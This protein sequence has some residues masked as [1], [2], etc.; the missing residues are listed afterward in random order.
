MPL[1]INPALLAGLG[2]ISIPIIIHLLQKN[3]VKE[4]EWAAMQFLLEIVEEQNKKIQIEDLILL[5]LRILF[6]TFLA[7]A[8]ARPVINFNSAGVLDAHGEV[9][10]MVDDSYSMGTVS[11]TETRF[12]VAK[13]HAMK[14]LASQP[15]GYGVSVVKFNQYSSSIMGGFSSD[16]E[17]IKEAVK[18]MKPSHLSGNIESGFDYALSLFK[19]KE[20]KKAIFVISDF[21]EIDWANPTEAFS[22][23]LKGLTDA[24]T[25]LFFIPVTDGEKENLA[26]ESVG[27]TQAAVKVGQ[28]ATIIGV[29]RNFGPDISKENQ[30]DLLVNGVLRDT[31]IIIIPVGQSANVMFEFVPEKEGDHKV[32]IKIRHDKLTQDNSGFFVLKVLDKLKILAVLDTAPARFEFNDLTPIEVALNPFKLRSRDEKALYNFH[33]IGIS[34]L[35]SVELKNYDLVLMANI[36]SIVGFEAKALEDYVKQ[37]GGVLMFLGDKVKTDTYNDNLFKEGKGL[38]SMKLSEKPLAQT[39]ERVLEIVGESKEHPIWQ[40]ILSDGRNYLN[41]ILIYKTFGFE[42]KPVAKRNTIVLATAKAEKSEALPMLVDFEFG[43][44]HFIVFGSNTIGP[45]GRFAI[46]PSFVAFVNQSIKYLRSFHSSESNLLIYSDFK[47]VVDLAESQ[48]TF[49]L[50]TPSGETHTISVFNENNA[51]EVKIKSQVLK[52]QGFYN[53]KNLDAPDKAE[54]LSVNLD[55]R[56]GNIKTLEKGVVE[57]TFTPMGV[58][59]DLSGDELSTSLGKIEPTMELATIFLILAF[60]FWVAENLLA[61]KITKR[62]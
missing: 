50:E 56:E 57:S 8:V 49:Q 18:K 34:D 12:D 17:I 40:Y 32:E 62:A 30:V 25:S 15:K 59:V 43:K 53:L 35:M 3:R 51:Y 61:Y 28:K 54:V 47:K 9:V 6:F 44:G 16:I 29:I 36:P 45:W 1:F 11:G 24:K 5:L 7:L 39:E 14:I 22:K 27:A 58:V 2:L 31:K 26:V 52:E 4:M 60:L 55:I 10:I 23:K 46:H 48:S 37:G 33:F 42:G 38:W 21:Q 20:A 13:K 19:N 41:P